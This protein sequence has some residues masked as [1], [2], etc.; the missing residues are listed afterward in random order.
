MC[1][2]VFVRACVCVSIYVRVLPG[3]GGL[4]DVISQE[5]GRFACTLDHPEFASL[6]I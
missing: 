3:V 5:S 6:L 4:E 2:C 1:V